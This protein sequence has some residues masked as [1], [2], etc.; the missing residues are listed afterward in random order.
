MLSYRQCVKVKSS[1]KHNFCKAKYN[2]KVNQLKR[3]HQSSFSHA[4]TVLFHFIV[5]VFCFVY[6]LASR[7][8][9]GGNSDTLPLILTV[10]MGHWKKWHRGTF[11]LCTNGLISLTVTT[12]FRPGWFTLTSQW[13][14]YFAPP[15]ES[16]LFFS[17]KEQCWLQEEI[18]ESLANSSFHELSE[19]FA[20]ERV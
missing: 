3:W 6:F 5:L 13:L 19:E 15:K 7:Y 18:S 16:D 17:L 11:Y 8:F 14:V 12:I 4:S 20:W 10:K 9:G 1:E 2:N